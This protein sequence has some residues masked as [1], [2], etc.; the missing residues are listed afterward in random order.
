MKPIRKINVYLAADAVMYLPFYLAKEKGI[1]STLLPNVTIE[2]CPA[3]GDND[4]IEKMQKDNHS[5]DQTLCAIAVTDPSVIHKYEDIQIIA[6]LIDRL[7][8][9]AVS[10]YDYDIHSATRRI[11]NKYNRVVYYDHNLLTG[12]KVGV[13]FINNE[14]IRSQ[15]LI[16]ELGEEFNYLGDQTLIITPDILNIAIHKIQSDLSINYHFAKG[17]KYLP[18]DYITTAIITDQCSLANSCIYPLLVSMVEAI[19][20]AKSI[21]YSSKTIAIEILENMDCLKNLDVDEETK[22][23]IA[24]TIIEIIHEDRIYPNDMNISKEKWIKTIG[25][26]GNFEFIVNT[27][28]VI[29]AEKKIANQFGITAHVTFA[30][31]IQKTCDSLRN[32]LSKSHVPKWKTWIKSHRITTLCLI[33]FVI[34]SVIYGTCS[35]LDCSWVQKSW[36]VFPFSSLLGILKDIFVKNKVENE[37]SC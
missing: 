15:V 24:R 21:I 25:E 36:A 26:E 7:S 5:T 37:F 1:F 17:D 20:K 9:W 27:G 34:W 28:L 18:N 35:Y 10:K 19:H 22:T 31:E 3:K 16:S 11:S 33:I 23:R 30:E 14:Q 32:E 13:Q 29:D 2:L 8:F 4:A 6:S 12:H